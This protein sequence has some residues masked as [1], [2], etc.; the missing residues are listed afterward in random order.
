VVFPC[1]AVLIDDKIFIYYGG[2]DSVVGVA[3]VEL[4]QLLAELQKL[5]TIKF[6]QN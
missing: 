6:K 1:G 2:G 3:T 4:K 5:H